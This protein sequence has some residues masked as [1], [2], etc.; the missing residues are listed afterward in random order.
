M[1]TGHVKFIIVKKCSRLCGIVMKKHTFSREMDADYRRNS[2]PNPVTDNPYISTDFSNYVR[3]TSF[4][5][6]NESIGVVSEDSSTLAAIASTSRVIQ[7]KEVAGDLKGITV[8]DGDS[9]DVVSAS[10]SDGEFHE[11]Y[12]Q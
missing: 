9:G 5:D 10:S 1:I 4:Y 12:L 7:A 2:S 6:M 3:P 11:V 8:S